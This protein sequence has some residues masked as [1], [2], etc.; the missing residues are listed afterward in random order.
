M[1]KQIA[2]IDK[3]TNR[4]KSV[5]VVETLENDF[6]QAWANETTL[7]VPITNSPAFV[8]GI[9]DGTSFA[10]PEDS[11]LLEIGVLQPIEEIELDETKTK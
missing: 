10:T 11:Y 6:I 7:V 4:V 1:E 2:L 3:S 8:H 9:Y 5:L